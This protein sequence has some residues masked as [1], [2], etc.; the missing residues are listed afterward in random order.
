MP[1]IR[2]G[3]GRAFRIQAG[4]KLKII[5]IGGA[6]VVDTWAFDPSDLHHR[7]SMEISRRYMYK[8]RP[9]VGDVLRTNYRE[10]IMRLDEDTSDGI[11]DTLIAACDTATYDKLGA[12][13]HRSCAGN[14]HESLAEIGEVL[15]YTPGPLNLFMNVPI[16]NN[17]EMSLQPS[18]AK[19]GEYVVL[20]ALM[21]AIVV[22]SSCPMDLVPTNSADCRISDIDGEVIGT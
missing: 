16:T 6:Q 10:P 15:P 11:H 13:G 5:N 8:L 19:P 12:K 22:I 14:L 3:H 1:R 17:L 7:M 2:A 20:E 9:S 18:R 21:D 4:Q